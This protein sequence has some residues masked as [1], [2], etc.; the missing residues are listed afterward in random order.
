MNLPLKLLAEL[1]RDTSTVGSWHIYMLDRKPLTEEKGFVCFVCLFVTKHT[2]AIPRLF[3]SEMNLTPS[4]IY[5]WDELCGH[6]SDLP[7][8][9]DSL[10]LSRLFIEGTWILVTLSANSSYTDVSKIIIY[11]KYIFYLE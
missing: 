7:F 9:L 3:I 6:S 4:M 1:K 8:L 2:Y 10:T 11:V 5:G